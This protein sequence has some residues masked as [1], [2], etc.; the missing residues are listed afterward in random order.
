[1]R[2][3]LPDWPG[4]RECYGTSVHH[5]PY[6]DGWEHRDQ[7]IAVY[8]KQSDQAA[9]LAIALRG[10]SQH[11][12][13][14][15]GGDALS[16]EEANR[17]SRAGI[18]WREEPIIRLRHDQGQL[19]GVELRGDAI[20]PVDALFFES[21]QH[22][23]CDLPRMLGVSCDDEF[24]GRTNRKQK[25]DVRGVF[26]AGDADG[27]VEFVVVAAAEGATAAVAIN[28]ELLEEDAPPK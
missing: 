20:V 9:G 13:V 4:L 6:C 11:I 26:L 12:T 28:R 10:W 7:R 23:G 8:A 21:V 27:N 14:L 22:R 16:S 15:T 3:E 19:Q 24:S 25:T 5:C 1:M 18:A 2:D 17:L